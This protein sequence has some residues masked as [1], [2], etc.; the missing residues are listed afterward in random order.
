MVARSGMLRREIASLG[1]KKASYAK[2]IAG[3][4]KV[5]SGAREAA[6]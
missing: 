4:E 5:A 1:D 2:A 3:Q 6:R